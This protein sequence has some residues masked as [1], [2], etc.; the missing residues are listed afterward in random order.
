M[1]RESRKRV[2][3]EPH[4]SST[5]DRLTNLTCQWLQS[6]ANGSTVCRVL[7]ERAPRERG[8]R[9]FSATR[10]CRSGAPAARPCSS[11]SGFRVSGFG[12]RV[13]GFRF[14]A[15][16]FGFQISGFGF[17]VSGFRFRVSGFGLRASC[18]GL[19]VSGFGFR[20]SG[21]GFRVSGSGLRVSGFRLRVSG[22]GLWAPGFGV[23]APG[24]GVRGSGFGV[25][26][27]GFGLRASGFRF[28]VS[29]FGF[30]VSGLVSRVWNHVHLPHNLSLTHT[31]GL[32]GDFENKK[33]VKT[34]LNKMFQYRG[35]S[36]DITPPPLGPYRRPRPRAIG[37]L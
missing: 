3:R 22:F 17:R 7:R 13:S 27:S 15:S 11:A 2:P 34:S 9:A 33:R 24:S 20:S 4:V 1:P 10:E 30:R 35:T 32:Q 12:L 14:R 26:G 8:A 36:L 23:R 29:G 18:S 5:R 16:G 31:V 6:Q 19:R 21:F 28:R 37:G 25:R